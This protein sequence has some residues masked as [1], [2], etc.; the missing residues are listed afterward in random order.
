M[1]THWKRRA[2]TGALT[3]VMAA[4]AFT[5]VAQA[6]LPQLS[7]GVQ[8]YQ[9]APSSTHVFKYINQDQGQET[10]W[11]DCGPTSVLMALL[12]NGGR[13]PS[14]YTEESQAAAITE[15]RGEAPSGGMEGTNYLNGPDIMSILSR[16][17]VEGTE[18]AREKAVEA[19]DQI[20]QGKKAIVLTQTDV[21]Y[22]EKGD[23]GYG[24][25]VYVSGYNPGTGTF[26]VN[27][28]LNRKEQPYEA[29]EDQ[30]RTMITSPA[31]G[32]MQWVYAI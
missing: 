2:T 21:L 6:D 22:D 20:K 7:T 4:T 11:V 28:P 24:H 13:I 5:G 31:K 12:D 25:F 32:N 9:A 29:T 10:Q 15:L 18:L 19:I 14:S 30:L 17:G 1:L 16:H 26:T 23:V 8:A 27:D 3:A